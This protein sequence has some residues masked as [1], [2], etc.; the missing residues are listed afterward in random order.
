MSLGSGDKCRAVTADGN[1]VDF[2]FELG[3]EIGSGRQG[4]IFLLSN[5]SPLCVKVYADPSSQPDLEARI[6]GLMQVPPRE[7]SIGQHIEVAWPVALCRDMTGRAVGYFMNH[8]SRPNYLPLDELL[9]AN[10]PARRQ[11]GYTWAT[12]VSWAADLARVLKKL[13]NEKFIVGDLCLENIFASADGRVTLIDVDSFQFS[14]AKGQR[15]SSPTWHAENSPPELSTAEARKWRTPSADC[16]ALAVL[17]CQILYEQHHP[18]ACVPLKVDDLDRDDREVAN[19]KSGL[20]WVTEPDRIRLHPTRPRPDIAPKVLRTLLSLSFGPG[21]C[22]DRVSAAEYTKALRTLAD[23]LVSCEAKPRHVYSAELVECPWCAREKQLSR[24]PF[25]SR[26]S[27]GR[28][29]PGFPGT[30]L[31]QGAPRTGRAIHGPTGAG[32]KTLKVKAATP[33]AKSVVARRR[34]APAAKNPAK[35]TAS[36]RPASAAVTPSSP[37]VPQYALRSNAGLLSFLLSIPGSLAVTY[38][39]GKLAPGESA[40]YRSGSYGVVLHILL[41]V[42]ATLWA[43][44]RAKALYTR[45]PDGKFRVLSRAEVALAGKPGG[46]PIKGKDPGRFRVLAWLMLTASVLV[47]L[48]GLWRTL[49]FKVL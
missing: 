46:F 24:D 26:D 11:G 38:L 2:V 5:H 20:S 37:A 29:F 33:P 41:I 48:I 43:S 30:W 25:P 17:I 42:T 36:P 4:S 16:F 32:K 10:S 49:I 13:H 35:S 28:A 18:F 39:I 40:Y 15:F 3:V 22:A 9:T 8:L 1:D 12:C 44:A 27:S 34:T 6:Y 47:I 45:D 14:D 19:I 23:Q 31:L 21:G 7:W